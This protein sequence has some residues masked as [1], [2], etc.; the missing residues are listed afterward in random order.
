MNNYIYVDSAYAIK[1]H[2]D[3]IRISGGREGFND[4]G[5]LGVCRINSSKT[6]N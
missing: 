4:I 2:D 3:I 5:L 6:H 1:V